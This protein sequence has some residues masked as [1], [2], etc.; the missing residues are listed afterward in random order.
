MAPRLSGLTVWLVY[1]LA[2]AAPLQ[3]AN[4]QQPP[5]QMASLEEV[6][7]N[8]DRLT[9]HQQF[10]VI[11]QLY[12]TGQPEVAERLLPLVKPATETDVKLKR[13]YGGMIAKAQGRLLEAIGTFR[14][15]LTNDPGFKRVRLELAH[16][17]FAAKEDE[18]AQ[19]HFELVL[20]GSATDPNVE[21]VVRNYLQA[22]NSR[23]AWELSSY[24]SIA[25]STN[26]N[27]GS[28]NKTVELNGLRFDLA[29]NNVKKSGLGVLAGFQGG[30]RTPL[31]DWL[32]LVTTVGVHAKRYNQDDFNDTLA[33]GSFGPRW[34]FENGQL[35]VYGTIDKRWLAD[36]ELSL[37]YGGVIAGSLRL[38]V[39]DQIHGDVGCTKRAYDKDW[40]HNDLSYQDGRTCSASLR[41]EHA[42][43]SVTYLRVL[44]S[45]A[46]ER[47][48]RLHLDNDTWSAGAGI[49]RELP[50]GISVY[51]Q[52]LYT[53]RDF[54]GLFPGATAA[55]FDQRVDL[56]VN[57]T[58]RD[59]AL[60]GL[61]PML[62]YTYTI[63][64]SNVGIYQYDAHGVSLT[65]TKRF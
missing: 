52:A 19:H 53:E 59:F 15:L 49:H 36:H 61:A 62:Q 5:G 9:P 22:I 28:A 30:Y 18:A 50:W 34:R 21:H 56:S 11:E 63:N 54:E 29:D 10:A 17:L 8:W 25:P 48:N 47:T 16:A 7:R 3:P 55:R 26:L 43:D 60:F 40:Q 32:D 24:V 45:Y 31:T 37:G 35:G 6:E 2:F 64:D 41:Y 44:G 58:K 12:Q 57:L 27:Q 38:G 33:T 42:F 13:F 4:A 46:Q 14:D 1:V 20:G 39:Q 65:L 51:T 23:R